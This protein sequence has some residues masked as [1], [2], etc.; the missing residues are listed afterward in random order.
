MNTNNLKPKD[1]YKL[2]TTLGVVGKT[3]TNVWKNGLGTIIN[4]DI[5]TGKCTT[6]HHGTNK[7]YSFRNFDVALMA[8]QS[9]QRE[10][11]L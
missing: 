7:K 5:K 4:E 11:R 1:I 8:T 2:H 9:W 6:T 3:K 10:Q